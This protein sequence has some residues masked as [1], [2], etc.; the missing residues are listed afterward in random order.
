MS[1]GIT[2]TDSLFSVREV[3]WHGMGV[4][5]DEAPKSIDDALEKSGLDWDVLQSP[6]LYQDPEEAFT[7]TITRVN[8]AG[9]EVT[10]ALVNTRS[11]TKEALGIVTDRYEVVQNRE[12]FAFLGNLIGSELHFETAGS[13][14]GGKRTWVMARMPEFI[15]VGGDLTGMFIFVTNAHDGHRSVRAAISP[16]RVVCQNTLTAALSTAPRTH[17]INHIGSSS[18]ALHEARQVLDVTINYAKQF[19]EL[20]D[21]LA[22]ESYTERRLKIALEKL[23]PTSDVMSDRQVGNREEARQSVVQLFKEGETVGNSPGTKWCAYNAVAEYVDYGKSTDHDGKL[24]RAMEDPTG[25]K[26]KALDLVT[27]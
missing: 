26:A 6:V 16:V 9:N 15:E 25:L 20:G 17:A 5:L 12:A 11:D 10:A 3:P 14:H 24:L 19:K 23:Y 13:L 7:H 22:S 1:A 18:A 2:K 8:G 27:A 4:V 21:Q